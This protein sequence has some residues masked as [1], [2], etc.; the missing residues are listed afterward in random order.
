MSWNKISVT[1]TVR[2]KQEEWMH[3]YFKVTDELKRWYA[4]EINY[5]APN[6][7]ERIQKMSVKT[8]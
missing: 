1:N 2:L 5:L 7:L 3:I 4:Y 6:K 8:V